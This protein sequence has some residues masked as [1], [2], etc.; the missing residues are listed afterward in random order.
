MFGD[1]QNVQPWG[2]P[3]LAR[4]G[5]ERP[6]CTPWLWRLWL[7][8]ARERRNDDA[9]GVQRLSKGEIRHERQPLD[10]AT[11]SRSAAPPLFARQVQ[12]QDFAPGHAGLE[13]LAGDVR[14]IVEPSCLER[15]RAQQLA[16]HQLAGGVEV[17]VVRAVHEIARHAAGSRSRPRKER[18]LLALA[19]SEHR[20]HAGPLHLARQPIE[21]LDG[22]LPVSVEHQHPRMVRRA[23]SPRHRNAAAAVRLVR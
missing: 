3:R 21:A 22:K 5:I 2:Q 18:V 7:R 12:D 9:V 14:R 16:V 19:R 1:E 23:D 11:D 6:R 20:P 17:P 15:Q 4:I 13:Q 10:A 8:L